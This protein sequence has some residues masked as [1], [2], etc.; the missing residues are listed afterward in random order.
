M[1]GGEQ[2]ELGRQPM[3]DLSLSFDSGQIR[4]SG[5]DVVGSFSLLG[6]ITSDGTVAIRKK[7]HGRHTVDY[8]G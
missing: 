7:Y 5:C 2:A 3:W 1:A 6:D 4:G 8:L